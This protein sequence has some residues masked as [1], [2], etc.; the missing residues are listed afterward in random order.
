MI[1]E[2]ID[3]VLHTLPQPSLIHVETI[4]VLGMDISSAYYRGR[5]GPGGWWILDE[6]EIHFVLDTDVCVQDLSGWR[7]ERLPSCQKDIK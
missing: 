4:S 5:G 1:G 3:G 7:R 2:I 6:P